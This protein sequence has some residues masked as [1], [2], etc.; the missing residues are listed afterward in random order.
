MSTNQ[1]TT[2]TAPVVI[3]SL[4]FQLPLGHLSDRLGRKAVLIGCSAAGVALFGVLPR[5]AGSTVL[6]VSLCFIVGAFL[7]TL[8]S[9]SLGYLGDLVGATNL[10]VGNQLAVTNL[11][12]GLMT[13][14]IVGGL[15]MTWL[16]PGAIFWMIALF[17]LLYICCSVLWSPASDETLKCDV[18]G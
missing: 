6:F 4:V 13:G 11:G 5:A 18:S 14:P 16:G 1:L 3:G 10:P 8:F 9:L 15:M 17:Y 2:K 7:D 12:I